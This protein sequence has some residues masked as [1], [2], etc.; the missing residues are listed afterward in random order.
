M[1]ND[2]DSRGKEGQAADESLQ[3]SDLRGVSEP[4]V[5]LDS[6]GRV[7][8]SLQDSNKHVK[9]STR[10]HRSSRRPRNRIREKAEKEAE[11]RARR[12]QKPVSEA[13]SETP[14][15]HSWNPLL[16]MCR[17]L[18]LLSTPDPK[19]KLIPEIPDTMAAAA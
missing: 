12:V 7:Q 16:R 1:S 4:V 18:M 19:K 3:G 8:R 13:S 11:A 9:S 14:P 5:D 6:L 17:S 2:T 15:A 10:G